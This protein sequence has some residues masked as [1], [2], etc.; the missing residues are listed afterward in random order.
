[1]GHE[2]PL[3]W[4]HKKRPCIYVGDRQGEASIDAAGDSVIEGSYSDYMASFHFAVDGHFNEFD[5]LNYNC[6]L[7]PSLPIRSVG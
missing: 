3:T 1:M 7:F 5:N 4:D 2:Y 6:P